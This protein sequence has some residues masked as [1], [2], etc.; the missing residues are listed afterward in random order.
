MSDRNV[1]AT[2]RD[3]ALED[4]LDVDRQVALGELSEADAASL[5][6]GYQ[7]EALA[8]ICLLEEDSG[9][10]DKNTGD[11][12]SATA[13]RRGL[14][15][16]RARY[17]VYTA[18]VAVAVTA[19]ALVPR[20]A[21]DRPD[22]GLVSGNE[23]L[24]QPSDAAAPT[25]PTAPRRA[26]P[27]SGMDLATVTDAQLER[28]V[29]ENP[30]VIGMRLA[31]AERYFVADRY[32]L[33]VVHYTKVLD[34]EPENGEALAHLGWINY[35]VGQTEQ[36]ARLLDRAVR[37][38]ADPVDALWFQANLRLYGESDPAGAIAALDALRTGSGLSTGVRDR[39]DQLRATASS[40]L[41]G[42]Q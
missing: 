8:A 3:Q 14:Q 17:A 16:G 5:R 12:S 40:R 15:R 30:T 35:R 42:K 37:T 23:V 32:D 29:S 27:S 22:G 39:V 34:Q 26:G 7:R 2:R 11:R 21:L 6:A 18:G 41:Q 4:L 20:F 25:A 33:A 24:Q 19:A 38:G 10:G 28:V 31:L 13:E 1:V 36:A 9:E